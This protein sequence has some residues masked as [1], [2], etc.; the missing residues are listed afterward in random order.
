MTLDPSALRSGIP[1]AGGLVVRW[2]GPSPTTNAGR[3]KILRQY[4][5]WKAEILQSVADQMG[6]SILDATQV[7]ADQIVMREYT[8][9]ARTPHPRG[10]CA[11]TQGPLFPLLF[12]TSTRPAPWAPPPPNT[13]TRYCHAAALSLEF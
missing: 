2:S 1:L 11:A 13:P 4:C 12:S 3:R 8:P 9:A 7:A 5:A 6:L 10:A